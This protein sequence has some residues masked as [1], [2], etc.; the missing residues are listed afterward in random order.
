VDSG[1]LHR[2]AICRRAGLVSRD[3]IADRKTLQWGMLGERRRAAPAVW[4]YRP[5]AT[6]STV[7]VT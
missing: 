3:S 7:P 1:R 5:P 6:R 4:V 2:C